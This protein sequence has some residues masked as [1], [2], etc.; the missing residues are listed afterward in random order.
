MGLQFYNINSR[1]YEK[2]ASRVSDIIKSRTPRKKYLKYYKVG[3]ILTADN[4]TFLR[5]LNAI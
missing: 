4:L 3:G 2:P 5:S 1:V